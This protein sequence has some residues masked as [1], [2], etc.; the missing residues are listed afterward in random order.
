MVRENAPAKRNPVRLW[1]DAP[2]PQACI[3][4]ERAQQN[5]R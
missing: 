4:G 2:Q 5:N 3:L 1:R